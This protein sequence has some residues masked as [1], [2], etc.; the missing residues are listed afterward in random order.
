M[1]LGIENILLIFTFREALGGFY[2]GAREVG[3]AVGDNTKKIV[4][5]K[6]GDDVT[7]TFMSSK[8]KDDVT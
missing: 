8:P 2:K 6:Y 5:K 1:Q 7:N 4:Q 3:G